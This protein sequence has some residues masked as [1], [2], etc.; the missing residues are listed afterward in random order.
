[1]SGLARRWLA[2][3]FAAAVSAACG[4]SPAPSAPTSSGATPLATPTVFR[5]V[6]QKINAAN[7]E[8]QLAW[9][10][11]AASYQLVIGSTPGSSNILP[12]TVVPG[13]TYT[14]ISPRTGGTY[15]ARVA[16]KSGDSL[17]GYSD[18]LS[19]FVLDIRNVIDA[20]YFHAGPMADSPANAN[21]NP[22]TAVWA[23]GTR[24]SVLVSNEAGST[25]LANAQTF[26]GQYADLIGGAVTAAFS[27]TSDAMHDKDYRTFPDFTIGVR[28]QPGYCGGALA[29][30]PTGSGPAPIG[31]NKSMVTLEQGSGLYL[32][33]TA[34]E[35]GHAYGMG[36]ITIPAA[37]RPE[38]RFMMSPVNASEQM[39][40]AEKLAIT[41]A[42][43]AGLR[44]GWTRHD[45]ELKDLVNP[46]TGNTSIR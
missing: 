43:N 1:M 45:A 17:S 9:V 13:T 39:T 26:T 6:A 33:A 3:V 44:A 35:M 4:S 36:H 24:L 37:G 16:A 15:Y 21:S 2:V 5:Q 46:Y 25:A 31:P 29:C 20:M 32:S 19:L 11:T 7:N 10:G 40:D 14:W 38:F 22:V 42:R 28:V 18:E 34:H 8:F 12:P 23:D 30:V 41:L 27:M